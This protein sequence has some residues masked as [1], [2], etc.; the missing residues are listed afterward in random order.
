MSAMQITRTGG[1]VLRI[2]AEPGPTWRRAVLEADGATLVWDAASDA[3]RHPAALVWDAR[4]A[5]AWLWQV[6]GA[7]VTGA[8]LGD[9]TANRFDA[10]HGPSLSFARCAALA[11]WRSSWWPA[12]SIA[13][14]P[15]LDEALV[16]A[17]RL[18]ALAEV[19]E[20]LDADLDEDVLSHVGASPLAA[21][22]ALAASDIP[23]ASGAVADGSAAADDGPS[24]DGTGPDGT[25]PDGTG[26]TADSAS[27]EESASVDVPGPTA[28]SASAEGQDVADLPV[29]A[30]EPALA[31][32]AFTDGAVRDA[33]SELAQRVRSL[34]A[35][36]PV[37]AAPSR[38]E[39]ALAAGGPPALPGALAS[40]ESPLALGRIAQGLIDAAGAVRWSILQDR[41]GLRL[42]V[43]L[44]GAPAA[45]APRE[46][47]SH[48]AGER[49]RAPLMARFCGTELALHRAGETWTGEASLAAAV[50]L[51]PAAQRVAEVWTPGLEDGEHVDAAALIG[52]A[53]A[54]TEAPEGIAEAEAAR[55]STARGAR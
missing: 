44:A 12:S 2:G 30:R 27:A 15:P 25:G 13:G 24:P 28:D 36:T 10:E 20:L 4:R 22:H 3:P 31:A 21:L 51:T 41:E 39:F 37:A 19:E 49:R 53:A 18:L 34:A 26:A 16:E 17:E 8:V 9:A 32:G 50:L 54:R 48:G 47:A 29:P 23:K 6:Y 5:T 43:T 33:A 14:I 40:G 35:E 46:A 55:R 45:G 1:A 42:V 52:L 38:E 11:A 7:G